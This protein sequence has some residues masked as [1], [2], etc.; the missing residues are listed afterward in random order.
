MRFRIRKVPVTVCLF[1]VGAVALAQWD[2]SGVSPIRFTGPDGRYSLTPMPG[3]T[4]TV[5]SDAVVFEKD[6]TTL[7]VFFHPGQTNT[8]DMLNAPLQ[9]VRETAKHYRPS[10]RMRY[11][12][13][14]YDAHTILFA[15]DSPENV[16]SRGRILTLT[17]G[18]DGMTFVL[19]SPKDNFKK[20]D[21]AVW[22]AAESVTFAP[23]PE[24]KGPHLDERTPV[25]LV[26]NQDIKSGRDH[27]GA[28]VWFTVAEAVRGAEGNILIARN[29]TAYGTVLRSEKRQMFGKPGKLEIGV[30][31]VQAVDGSTVPLRAV[32]NLSER[33]RNNAGVVTATALLL[34]P[35]TI[36]IKGRDVTVKKG[37]EIVA[38]V[39][40]DT[41]VRPNNSAEAP[42]VGAPHPAGEGSAHA[43][44]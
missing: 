16:P 35:V 13:A 42:S 3:W 25:H 36:F 15:A 18:L 8:D 37:T 19:I 21:A 30:T 44:S 6:K 7:T 2:V 29:A 39:N 33:G 17:N 26:L 40:Q 20:D 4:S 5:K 9:R 32:E 34:T 12:V 43:G 24:L 11:S 41:A 14:S 38:Y 22:A 1:L 10:A 31:S 28:P 23:H 27:K